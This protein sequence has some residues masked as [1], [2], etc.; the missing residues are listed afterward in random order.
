M[1]R[2]F[3]VLFTELVLVGFLFGCSFPVSAEADADD[4][5]TASQVAAQ[6]IETAETD[7]EA[8]SNEFFDEEEPEGDL[9]D[10][11]A[12]VDGESEF[13][14]AEGQDA[15]DDEPDLPPL[16]KDEEEEDGTPP[17]LNAKPAVSKKS[18]IANLGNAAEAL[19]GPAQPRLAKVQQMMM[20]LDRNGTKSLLEHELGKVADLIFKKIRTGELNHSE[21]SPPYYDILKYTDFLKKQQE[22]HESKKKEAESSGFFASLGRKIG[23]GGAEEESTKQAMER[24]EQKLATTRVDLARQAL[25]LISRGEV[26][27]EGG[28]DMVAVIDAIDAAVSMS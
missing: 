3:W 18:L 4:A 27:I 19:L 28:A 5:L 6:A 7:E 20:D 9:V 2:K 15:E 17:P 11:A 26:E 24:L 23:L 14:E 25:D 1:K 10:M 16:K 21:L 8:F 12:V 13:P 22:R